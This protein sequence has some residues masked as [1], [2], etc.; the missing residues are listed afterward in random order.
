M[1]RHRVRGKPLKG[2]V[3]WERRAK[4]AKIKRIERKAKEAAKKRDGYLCRRCGLLK[5]SNEAAHIDT[6]G[7][8]G[9]HGL[10]SSLRSDYVT[11]C[12]TCHQGPRSLHSGHV[13]LVCGDL[14][15]D[16][17]VT[18]IEKDPRQVGRHVVALGV[19]D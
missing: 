3:T 10:H 2:T 1:I 19:S 13:R 16:G 4:A 8:G 18:F 12:N 5:L 17:P 9:D 11:L 7:M 15:G 14:R 6:K